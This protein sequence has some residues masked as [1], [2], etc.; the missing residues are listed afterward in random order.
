MRNS[1]YNDLVM[2]A[3][4][5]SLITRVSDDEV[6]WK[7]EDSERAMEPFRAHTRFEDAQE[8]SVL[9]SYAEPEETGDRSIEYVVR[10]G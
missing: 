9:P 8:K 2:C 6:M 7:S 1:P 5:C 4:I 3:V 10:R